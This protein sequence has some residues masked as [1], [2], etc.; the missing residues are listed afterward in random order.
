M[1]LIF[2]NHGFASGYLCL[3]SDRIDRIYRINYTNRILSILLIL[4]KNRV[5]LY[6][7]DCSHG[8]QQVTRFKCDFIS[9]LS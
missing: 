2:E 4:S 8:Y 6:V 7:G 5:I 9:N 1:C 3:I